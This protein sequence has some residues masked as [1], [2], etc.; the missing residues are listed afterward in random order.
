VE[1]L[2]F[3]CGR[4]PAFSFGMR[5]LPLL[6]FGATLFAQDLALVRTIKFEN[7]KKVAPSEILDRLKER[8]TRL[9]VEWPYQP[10]YAAEARDTIAELLREKGRPNAKIEIATKAVAPRRV[11]V[12]FKLLK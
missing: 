2:H 8:E 1:V 12:R 6:L 10:E 5:L 11:E 4:F 3:V 9:R 7:F